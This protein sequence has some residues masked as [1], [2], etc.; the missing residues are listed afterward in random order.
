MASKPP[1]GR[2]LRQSDIAERAGVSQAVVSWVVNDRVGKDARIS[3]ETRQRVLDAIDELG[4]VVDPAAQ[5]LAGG[6]TG[7]LGVYTFE[8]VFPVDHRDFYY[9]FLLGIEEEAEAQGQD[10]LLFTSAAGEDRQRS[11]YHGGINRLRRTDGCVLLGKEGSKDE[12]VRLV[13]DEFPFAF[14]GRRD[15]PGVEVS[16][17]AADYAGGAADVVV[18]LASLGHRRVGYISYTN[19]IES[20][21]DREV[22]F[23]QGAADAGFAAEAAPVERVDHENVDRHAIERLLAGGLTAIVVHDVRLV[24]PVRQAAGARGLHIPDDLSLAVLEDPP[25][26]GEGPAL[27]GFAIPRRQMGAVALRLLI[28][29]LNAGDAT[30]RQVVLD[31]PLVVGETTGPVRRP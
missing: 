12:L 19:R 11:I 17:V 22:G 2:R 30:V 1:Q 27:T 7:I 8:S 21:I 6:R 20:V 31:C 28:E 13:A 9:P 29:R 26:V 15:V 25:P 16:F 10:L 3:A 14:V 23:V 24:E 4:Y 5:S 18:H